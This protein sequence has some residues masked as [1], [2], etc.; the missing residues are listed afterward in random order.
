MKLKEGQVAL[1]IQVSKFLLILFF[2]FSCTSPKQIAT[3]SK[4]QSKQEIDYA[5]NEAHRLYLFGNYA[6]ASEIYKSCVSLDDSCAVGFY[7]LANIESLNKNL[8]NALY[9]SNRAN[10]IDKNNIWYKNQLIELLKY[11]S[12]YDTLK[13]I[14]PNLIRLYPDKV[15]YRFGFALV[16]LENNNEESA[17]N[18]LDSIDLIVGATENVTYLKSKIYYNKKD[19]TSAE[20]LTKKLIEFD[21]T[22]YQ[23]LNQLGNVYLKSNQYPKAD[24]I[25]KLNISYN[26]SS[27]PAFL[28]YTSFLILSRY[29]NSSKYVTSLLTDTFSIEIKKNFIIS[30]LSDSTV[31][32]DSSTIS[33]IEFYLKENKSFPDNQIF[34]ADI[35]IKLKRY[36]EAIGYIEQYIKN[37]N[38]SNEVYAQLFTLYNITGNYRKMYDLTKVLSGTKYPSDNLNFYKAI[39]SFQLEKYNETI[40]AISIETVKN[41]K[42]RQTYLELLSE[43]YFKLGNQDSTI[44]ACE[45]VLKL[46]PNNYSLKNNYAYYLSVYDKQ[47]SRA[48][49]LITDVL[50]QYPDN[51]TYL[52]TYAWILYQMN[53]FD[54]AKT[55]IDIALSKGGGNNPEILDHAGDIYL[56]LDDTKSAIAFWRLSYNLTKKEDTL[57]KLNKYEK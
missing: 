55:Y 38:T 40:A 34:L 25:L 5:L 51:S 3:N 26:Y 14:Y 57:K 28:D 44:W 31:L 36:N 35:N 2:F 50:K 12:K 46:D 41:E 45:E 47:L 24:S 18:Q 27:N 9:Y 11:S 21:S 43:V 4:K 19:Y 17:F 49:I 37:G 52:D 7:Q 22:N 20:N 39:S 16:L 10:S 54:K 6:Q 30:A 32:S 8:N 23:Y 53:K 29:K 1:D 48:E 42:L 13:Y 15:E 56:V 33:S